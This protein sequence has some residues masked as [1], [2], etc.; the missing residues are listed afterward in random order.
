MVVH[1][2]RAIPGQ[3][4]TRPGL[5]LSPGEVAVTGLSREMI[6]CCSVRCLT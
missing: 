3:P 5:K 6:V 1:R 2:R 4:R